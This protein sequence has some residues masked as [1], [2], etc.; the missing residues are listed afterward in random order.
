M[1]KSIFL[2]LALGF[3]VITPAAVASESSSK[4]TTES[5]QSTTE[6]TKPKASR[7][8][9]D[10]EKGYVL[11]CVIMWAMGYTELCQELR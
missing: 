2:A 10:G 11:G 3:A 6:S 8:R 7:G 9:K 1:R 4:L 5:R